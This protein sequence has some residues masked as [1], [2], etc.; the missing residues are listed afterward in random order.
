[1]KDRDAKEQ[2]ILDWLKDKA[3]DEGSYQGPK[4]GREAGG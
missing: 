2:F 3:G 1:M 4:L